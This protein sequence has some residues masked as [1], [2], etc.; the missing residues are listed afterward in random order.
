MITF[1]GWFKRRYQSVFRKELDE[2][3]GAEGVA[4]IKALTIMSKSNG[5]SFRSQGSTHERR[6]FIE[7]SLCITV[8]MCNFS[9]WSGERFCDVKIGRE[10]PAFQV[11]SPLAALPHILEYMLVDAQQK[12]VAV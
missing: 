3:F 4:L 6:L 5:L 9:D 12:I 10:E 7:G 8:R 2:E 1:K 11:A